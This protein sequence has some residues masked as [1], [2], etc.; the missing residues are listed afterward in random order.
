M[1]DYNMNYEQKYIATIMLE[2]IYTIP[3]A[4]LENNV[5]SCFFHQNEHIFK[6]SILQVV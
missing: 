4:P 1:I 5:F 3:P 6:S 2:H